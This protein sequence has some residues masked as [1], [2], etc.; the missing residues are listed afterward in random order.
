MEDTWMILA[1]HTYLCAK[2]KL[3]TLLLLS[4]FFVKVRSMTF[5][6]FHRLNKWIYNM[7]ECNRSPHEVGNHKTLD[8]K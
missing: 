8:L 1:A 3:L 2:H 4:I 5:W 6:N 7:S